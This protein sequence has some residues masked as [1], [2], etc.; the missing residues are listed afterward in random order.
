MN[1]VIDR[2][3]G[4]RIQVRFERRDPTGRWSPISEPQIGDPWQRGI[5]AGIAIACAVVLAGWATIQLVL[6]FGQ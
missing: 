1:Y 5:Q 2:D 4:N 3:T 6:I